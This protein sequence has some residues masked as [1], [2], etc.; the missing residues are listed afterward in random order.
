[1]A[2]MIPDVPP[3]KKGS[4]HSENEFWTELKLQLS[5]AFYVYHGLPYLTAEARQGEVDF[6][7]LHR[8]YGLLNVECKGGGVKREDNG[9]WY[10]KDEYG[11]PKRLNRS[12]MEQAADQL[13]AIVKG[14]CDPLRR[15]LEEHF[16]DFPVLYGW[17]LAFPLSQRDDLN[18]P[19]DLQPEIVID[20]NDIAL[21]LEAKVVEA[22]RFHARKLG[23]KPPV[24]SPEQFEIFRSVVSPEVAL[25]ET[26]AGRIA[27]DKRAMRRLSKEQARGV[28]NVLENRRLR[29]R[30]GAGTGKTV[31]A[32]HAAKKLAEQGKRVLITCFNIKL[33]DFIASTTQGWSQ[34][35]GTVDVHHFHQL[36]AQAG[37]D[38]QGGLNYP[39]PG[40]S[41]AEQ[42]EF[43]NETAPFAVFRAVDSDKFSMGPWDAI[44]VDE[45][46]D[47]LPIWWEVLE[48]CLQDET[49]SMAIFYDERQNI[50]D[51]DT[52]I[53]E[54]GLVYALKENFRN[55]KEILR[56]I[57]PLC[58]E[59][60]VSHPECIEGKVPSVYQQGSPS[61]T[62]ERVGELLA[63]LVDRQNI[64]Y[65]QI[66]ILT[67][68]SPRNSSLEGA[69]ELG[70]VP[71]VHVVDEWQSGVLHSSISGF[72][73]LEADIVIL[74]DID[75]S[76]PRCSVN[77][78]YVAASRAKHR[79]H[80]FEKGN[81]LTPH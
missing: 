73:G 43:W 42:A 32:L 77:A 78:R 55:T 9:R 8:E 81:W 36:C 61:K 53:P 49:S 17:A 21:D 24:L 52:A 60:L 2:I 58:E 40:A 5:D 57:E 59:T 54:W 15:N 74:V 64:K 56:A 68:R 18:L 28:E 71:I 34:L 79:L 12:P 35:K 11:R 75:P 4:V 76:D 26:T 16:R 27:L 44:L 7:V 1:M 6:L 29:V 47:F 70:G 31:M 13:R 37:D 65:Q 51:K 72:K 25:E 41:A 62:R 46:Q 50:F 19:L 23:G 38:I 69:R 63:K 66:A 20:S 67:P 39:K 30:G 80:V 22:F 14:L 48:G 3:S 10:R 45:A 33:A